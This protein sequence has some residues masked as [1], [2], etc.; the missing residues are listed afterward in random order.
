[1]EDEDGRSIEEINER[2]FSQTINSETDQF[3]SM[4]LA[5][6]D[7][8]PDGKFLPFHIVH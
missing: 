5:P 3:D 2:W 7:D 8:K 4:D 6:M 1:M